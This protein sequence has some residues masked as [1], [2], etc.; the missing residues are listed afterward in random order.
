MEK[1]LILLMVLMTFFTSY[2]QNNLSITDLK[3]INIEEITTKFDIQCYFD[4]TMLLKK[5]EYAVVRNTKLFIK[6]NKKKI[7]FIIIYL[8]GLLRET[9]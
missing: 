8:S 1:K 3:R 4:D 5:D 9:H 6:K 2:G 7:V